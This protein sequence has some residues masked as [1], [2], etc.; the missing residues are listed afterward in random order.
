MSILVLLA[1]IVGFLAVGYSTYQDF[2]GITGS[3]GGNAGKGVPLQ[4]VES[5]NTA[6]GTLN[7]TISNPGLFPLAVDLSCSAAQA[8]Y[9]TCVPA[10]LTIP[11]G[12]QGQLVFHITISDLDALE[13]AG[14]G[15]NGTVKVQLVPVLSLTLGTTFARFEGEGG[16]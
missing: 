5:G 6:Q 4:L 7:A 13:A 9:V 10:S 15:L 14:G 16:G 12:G 11:P 3:F 2:Q 8:S 1:V